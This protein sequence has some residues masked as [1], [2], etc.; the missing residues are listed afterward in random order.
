MRFFRPQ[1]YGKA[2]AFPTLSGP[3][4]APAAQKIRASR[5][6]FL[7]LNINWQWLTWLSGPTV[8]LIFYKFFFT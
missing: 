8:P 5:Q 3:Y 7:P 1:N 6:Q 4:P 2:A